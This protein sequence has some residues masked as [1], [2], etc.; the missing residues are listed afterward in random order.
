MLTCLGAPRRSAR[1]GEG[2]KVTYMQGFTDK[3]KV[4]LALQDELRSGVSSDSE[5]L[6]ACE[7]E[8]IAELSRYF[9]NPERLERAFGV[10]GF[11]YEHAFLQRNKLVSWV[12]VNLRLMLKEFRDARDCSTSLCFRTWGS[13]MEAVDRGTRN[14]SV[15]GSLQLDIGKLEAEFA[16]KSILRDVGDIL[17]GSIQPL[18][19]LRLAMREVAGKRTGRSLPIGNM[20]FGDVIAELAPIG[21]KG[22]IYRPRPF[23][24]SVSQWRNIANHNSYTVKNDR[25]A[26]TYVRPGQEKQI[27]CTINDLVELAKYV[28]TLGFLHKVAF[29]IF[30]TDN[31]NELAPHA[32]RLEIT[33]FTKDGALVIGLAKG[34]F[35]IVKARYRE[36]EWALLLADDSHRDQGEIKSAIQD[37]VMPYF[38]LA[39]PTK[40]VALV[41]A[42]TS[43][44]RFSFSA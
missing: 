10:G 12:D 1:S 35:T 33:E 31:L 30:S 15:V 5:E 22:D 39:G 36:R 21:I 26:C 25:V 8:V 19:R 2:S 3:T 28:D 41:K 7:D 24:V 23:G 34:R 16:T 29:E 18:V 13:F 32:P 40:F 11:H 14:V 27:L 43:D 9:E 6:C 37:A 20:N 42:G 4:F 44:F 17:E 38:F